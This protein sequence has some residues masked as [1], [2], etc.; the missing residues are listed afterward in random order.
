MGERSD[1]LENT[2]L[3]VQETRPMNRLLRQSVFV[4]IMVGL[5]TSFAVAQEQSKKTAAELPPIRIS[6]GVELI[7]PQKWYNDIWTPFVRHSYNFKVLNRSGERLSGGSIDSVGGPKDPITQSQT[8]VYRVRVVFDKPGEYSVETVF[9][10][11][12][13]KGNPKRGVNRRNVI[14]SHPTLTT[15]VTVDPYYYYGESPIITFSTREFPETHGYTYSVWQVGGACVDTGAGSNIFLGKII[16]NPDNAKKNIEFE[17]R[18]YYGGR[19]FSFLRPQD[20]TVQKSTWRFKVRKPSLE[21]VGINWDSDD[22]TEIGNLPILPMD[23]QNWAYR[24]TLFGYAYL[25]RKGNSLIVT[26]AQ[27]SNLTIESD[28]LDFLETHSDP[29]IGKI[30]TD[31][32]ITP[33]RSFLQSGPANEPKLVR[34]TFTFKTQLEDGVTRSYRALVY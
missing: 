31:V 16:N 32:E 2:I 21:A 18:G 14:V 24:P 20:T 12:D 9:N 3:M 30:W 13:E 8:W 5:G 4:F 25:G 27:I 7:L 26:Q 33:S 15:P 28:P 11:I 10:G 6:T 34:L 22:N 23:A 17:A 1:R 29:V 19:L